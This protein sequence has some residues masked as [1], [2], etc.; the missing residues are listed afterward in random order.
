MDNTTTYAEWCNREQKVS[1]QSFIMMLMYDGHQTQISWT[2]NN[3]NEIDMSWYNENKK[4]IEIDKVKLISSA[5]G[6]LNEIMD[7]YIGTSSTNTDSS[8]QNN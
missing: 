3:E 7:F 6:L 8:T 4:T 1:S 2:S 5:E